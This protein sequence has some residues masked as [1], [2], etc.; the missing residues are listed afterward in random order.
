M[1]PGSSCSSETD[2][3]C[4][5]TLCQG[6]D[7]CWRHH[8]SPGAVL[9]TAEPQSGPSPWQGCLC[10]WGLPGLGQAAAA[11][12]CRCR[13]EDPGFR[14]P[15][16]G[17]KA[18][19]AAAHPQQHPWSVLPRACCRARH[20]SGPGTWQGQCREHACPAPPGW[21]KG[22]P[23]TQPACPKAGRGVWT[24]RGAT[25]RDHPPPPSS[26]GAG[27]AQVPGEEQLWRGARKWCRIGAGWRGRKGGWCLA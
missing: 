25:G 14:E 6:P 4:A 19:R 10:P 20:P 16:R 26:S 22:H 12:N 3:Y 24:R 23:P 9:G 7:G 13:R 21:E 5:D 11:Q 1:A 17:M 8:S 2:D 18:E 27:G 15:E